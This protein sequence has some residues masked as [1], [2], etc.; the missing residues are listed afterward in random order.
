MVYS[1]NPN[2]TPEQKKG[3]NQLFD[4]FVESNF[5]VSITY[6]WDFG[7]DQYKDTLYVK[8]TMTDATTLVQML[9]YIDNSIEKLNATIIAIGE[10]KE[11]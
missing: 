2:F 3:Q 4:S 9:D 7:K 8:N 10:V 5:G 6:S 1:N 11:Q